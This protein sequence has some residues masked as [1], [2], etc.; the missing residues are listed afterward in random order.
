M[1]ISKI[2]TAGLVA[3]AVDNTILDLASNYSFSGS[4]SGAS[5]VVLINTTTSTDGVNTIELNDIFSSTY[6]YYKIICTDLALKEGTGN[7]YDGDAILTCR[8]KLS[9]QSSY[10]S[11][12][13]NYTR[14]SES[15]SNANNNYQGENNAGGSNWLLTPS[16]AVE[17][18]QYNT[19]PMNIQFDVY[20]P[21]STNTSQGVY[22]KYELSYYSYHP[23]RLSNRGHL[24]HANNNWTG[25]SLSWGGSGQF[26]AGA[27]FKVYGFK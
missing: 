7:E 27:I 10:D 5:D 20:N 18:G 24:F 22:I 2:D 26:H 14:R 4:I 17:D 11:G 12:S 21:A 25:L 1:A 9:G 13:S 8:I 23:Y 6:R 3:D 15:F 19:Y 16:G